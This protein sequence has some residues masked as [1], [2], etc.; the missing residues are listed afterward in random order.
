MTLVLHHSH[1]LQETSLISPG[2]AARDL[3]WQFLKPEQF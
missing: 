1:A 2:V 3:P